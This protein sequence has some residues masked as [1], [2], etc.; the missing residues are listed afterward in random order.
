MTSY[1]VS[2]QNQVSGTKE[3]WSKGKKKE[4]KERTPT[5]LGTGGPQAE[6]ST[7]IEAPSTKYEYEYYTFNEA[8][9]LCSNSLVVDL[10]QGKLVTYGRLSASSLRIPDQP[11]G[12]EL[13]LLKDADSLAISSVDTPIDS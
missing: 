8:A 13:V 3:G 2:H 4:E 10:Q 6:P 9:H 7:S 5:L 1:F 12:L 11:L